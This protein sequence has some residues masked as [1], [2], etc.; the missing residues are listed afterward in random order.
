MEK[1]RNSRD[2]STVDDMKTQLRLQYATH[3][4]EEN[5]FEIGYMEPGHGLK[6]RKRWIH[7]D[8]DLR[9]M[10]AAYGTRK[11]VVI[12]CAPFRDRKGQTSKRPQLSDN[13]GPPPQKTKFAVHSEKMTEVEEIIKILKTKHDSQY[14]DE[15]LRVWAHMIHPQKTRLYGKSSLQTFFQVENS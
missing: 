9:D 14:T 13:S 4:P 5:D 1:W 2:F 10:Y 3:V 15:Q 7:V 8:D 12:W 6:G 11:E